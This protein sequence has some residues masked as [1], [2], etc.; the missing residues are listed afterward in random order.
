MPGYRKVFIWRK[1]VQGMAYQGPVH[2]ILRMENGQ[3]G[4]VLKAGRNHVIIVTDPDGIR[5]GI[6]GIQYRVLIR[7]ITLVSYPNLRYV[8]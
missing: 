1:A 2:Q 6:I 7:S 4:N 8:C 3:A 5:V